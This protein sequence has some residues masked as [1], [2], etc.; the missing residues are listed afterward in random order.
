VNFI[1]EPEKSVAVVRSVDV[2]VLGGSCTG[3]FAAVRAARLGATVA[4]VEKQNCFGG[5]ATAGLV[6]IWHSIY[7]AEYNK[8]IVGGLT[9]EVMNRMKSR[10]AVAI[11]DSSES[12]FYR[13]NSE[14]LKIELDALVLENK[15]IPFLHTFYCD[16]AVD[17]DN[18]IEAIFVENKSGRQAIRAKVFI[19]ATGDGDVAKS[20]GFPME[21][22]KHPLP[23]TTCAKIQGINQI[24]GL[25]IGKFINEHGDEFGLRKDTGWSG[26]I[27]D[28][29]DVRMY[30][31]TH[32][33]DMSAIAGLSLSNAEIEGRLQ[34]HAYM[35]MI[36]KYYPGYPISLMSLASSI[37]LRDSRRCV[38]DYCLTGDDVLNGRRFDDAI[39]NG[40][41]RVDVHNEDTGGFEFK[42]LDGTMH[43][44]SSEGNEWSRWRKPIDD[45]PTFYQI[46]YRTMVRSE[47]KNLIVSGRA[48]CVDEIAFGAV[49]VMV[50]LNQVG[51]ASGVAA[52]LACNEG[53]AVSDVCPKQLRKIL[54]DGGSIII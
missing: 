4:I 48:I 54:A 20:V 11:E 25:N 21:D 36:R 17:N 7:D 41:Y 44:M 26:L 29:F 13:F 30:A 8:Q 27:P 40:S 42:Y 15:I 53:L 47:F 45:D 33:F 1:I 28:S 16:V 50:N 2:C 9:V 19:D 14:E 22:S 52:V 49:R 32:V 39:A 18:K 35:N 51:E 31:M 37:G 38:A 12:A 34:V 5:M 6:N 3:V 24:D 46:P 23:P 10:G 43:V